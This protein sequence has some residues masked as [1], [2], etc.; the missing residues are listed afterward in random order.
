[1]QTPCSA[2]KNDISADEAIRNWEEQL[3][4]G[5][6]P[7]RNRL[8][9][10]ALAATAATAQRSG[11][12]LP[13]FI[14]RGVSPQVALQ[15]ASRIDPFDRVLNAVA[16]SRSRETIRRAII[17]TC[18]VKTQRHR[19][20]RH[21]QRVSLALEPSRESLAASL[22]VNTQ[23]RKINIPLVMFLARHL[24]Y[25]D[26]KLPYDLIKGMGIS[27]NIQLSE[28]L[29]KHRMLPT[30]NMKRLKTNLVARNRN[31]FR[32]LQSSTDATLQNKC[33]EMSVAEYEKGWLSK[34]TPVT[35][36]D[37]SFTVLSP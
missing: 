37:R 28:S 27:G 12:S 11:T 20:I 31:I 33:W 4:S 6:Q 14:P 22:P 17:N 34:P 10:S 3:R 18:T 25:P 23:A 15:I 24:D 2:T 8:I 32:H 16:D 30:S 1:M 9:E 35:Q 29:T 19:M 21:L 5:F 26:K 7:S 13:G 36:R